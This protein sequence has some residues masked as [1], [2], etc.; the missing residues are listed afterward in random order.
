MIQRTERYLVLLTAITSEYFIMMILTSDGS[1]GR[2]R[3]ELRK[4]S[5]AFHDELV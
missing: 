5:V 1:L 4:A 3:Y 2:A